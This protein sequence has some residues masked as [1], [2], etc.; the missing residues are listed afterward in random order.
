ML[1]E[2]KL[3]TIEQVGHER[4]EVRFKLNEHVT[5]EGICEILHERQRL[6]P[7][8][9]RD[10]LAVIPGEP[11]FDLDVVTTNHYEGLGLDNCTR[12]LAIAASS[13]INERM[14]GL[15]FAYFPQAFPARVF[16][17][18]EDARGWLTSRAATAS[19]S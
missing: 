16:A 11:D 18:E 7:E 12:A 10:V 17:S 4:L 8:G 14:A 15:F 1:I 13:P 6:C 2:T 9:P 19:L 3:A 5:R